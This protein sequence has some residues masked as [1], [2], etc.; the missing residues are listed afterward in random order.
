[1]DATQKQI[2]D[3]YGRPMFKMDDGQ[4]LSF[5]RCDKDDVDELEQMTNEE[6]LEEGY[7]A[8]MPAI[9]GCYSVRDLQ[10]EDLVWHEIDKR[11][12]EQTMPEEYKSIINSI[13]DIGVQV[14]GD[15]RG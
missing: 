12:L 4:I 6:L 9:Q 13:N 8:S 7:A 2:L 1:M 3:I 15:D 10:Y 5:A 11:N 14:N